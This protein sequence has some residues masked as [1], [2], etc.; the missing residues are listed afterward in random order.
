[1]ENITFQTWV[2]SLKIHGKHT[3]LAIVIGFAVGAATLF[4]M[5][6]RFRVLVPKSQRE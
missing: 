1:M 5:Q 4:T 6:K 2:G 3:I